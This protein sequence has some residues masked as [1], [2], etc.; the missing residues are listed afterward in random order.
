MDFESFQVAIPL[1]DG[2]RPY[3]QIVF[4]F[5]VHI[6]E[7]EGAEPKHISFVHDGIDDPR[8]EFAEE[9]KKVLG[10]KGSFVVFSKAFEVGR[11][12]ELA[13]DFPKY[14]D[15]VEFVKKR[16][17]DLYEP[18]GKFY[19]YNPKQNGKAGLKTILPLLTGKDYSELDIYEGGMA[20][21]AYLK[22]TYD[23]IPN[24]Q[25]KKMLEVI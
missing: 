10:K 4:Q 8:P 19:Y 16:I 25:K 14:K 13:K 15:W 12:N 7:K 21:R 24:Q 5:S 3:Q 22:M 11:L 2:S 20:S 6:V 1:F 9:L 23:T 17:I 18:F